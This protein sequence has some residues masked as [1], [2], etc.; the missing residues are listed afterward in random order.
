[1]EWKISYLSEK[2]IIHLEVTG[3]YDAIKGLPV[4]KA[5]QAEAR[6]YGC[7][8]WLLDMRATVRYL[9]TLHLYRRPD[10]YDDL[11]ISAD[12]RKALVFDEVGK[13]ERFYET[14][15]RNRGFNILVFSDIGTAISWLTSRRS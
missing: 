8:N 7:L 10:V 13:R 9:D 3:G 6:R 11:N 5:V 1:M 15:C 12:V 2:D 4:I 14:V